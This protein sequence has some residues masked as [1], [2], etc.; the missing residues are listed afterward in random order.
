MTL[1]ENFKKYGFLE[2]ENIFSK[3][4]IDLIN[5]KAD[6]LILKK[7]NKTK[8]EILIKELIESGIADII[9]TNENLRKIILTIMPDPILFGFNLYEVNTMQKKTHT[10]DNSADGWHVD[11]PVLPFLDRKQTNF[12]SF[13]IY[14]TDVMS[15]EDGP[16]EVTSENMVEK[17]KHKSQSK[18]ILGCKGTSFIWNNNYLH[19]ASPNIG[20][21]RRRVLK[22]S[23]QNN[24]FQNSFYPELL[25]AYPS[26]LKKD[27]FTDFVFGKYHL[28]SI[29][30]HKIDYLLKNYKNSINYKKIEFN[31]NVKLSL[32]LYIR[33]I[34]KNILN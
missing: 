32:K 13:I 1:V 6:P 23:F 11:T 31:S 12:V 2:L 14:L 30:A 28:T 8:T 10:N 15:F 17:L 5:I 29:K 16:F 26:F 7:F 4:Q 33:K 21:I 25:N 9:L 19:R 27:D 20:K 22:I 3:E 24:Y 34:L 18:K